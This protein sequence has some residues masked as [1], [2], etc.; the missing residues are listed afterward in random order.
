ML[1]VP[2]LHVAL[3]ASHAAV[4]KLTSKSRLDTVNTVKT[5]VTCLRVLCIHRTVR[6][7]SLCVLYPVA[8]P[9]LP[10]REGRS[11]TT[12]RVR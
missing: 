12:V 1:Y 8:L 5:P 10:L 4:L 6:F 2:K 7:L 11:G 9:Y 3:H